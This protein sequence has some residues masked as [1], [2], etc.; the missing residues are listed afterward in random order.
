MSLRIAFKLEA[1]NQAKSW[2]VLLFCMF[3]ALVGQAMAQLNQN[4]VVSVLNR[5]V[6]VN[7]DGSW[8]LPNVPANFGLVRARATCVENGVTTFGQS[9]LFS[10]VSNQALNLPT[11][12]LGVTNPVPTAVTL[13]ANNTPLTSAGA[14]TQLTVTA[15]YA[16]A[17][18]QDVTS[19]AS[20]TQYTVSN[21]AIATVSTGGLITAVSSGTAVVQAVNEGRQ[22]ILNIQVVLAGAEHGGIPDSWAIAHGLDPTDPAMPFEDPDHD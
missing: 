20:G 10:L 1:F 18:S 21:P 15:I 11:I 6:P 14:T 22:G 5:T 19:E 16:N 3:L 9:A 13:V 7:A 8:V 2:A 12:Q 4:C 17:P